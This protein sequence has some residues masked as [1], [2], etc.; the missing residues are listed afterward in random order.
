VECG[1]LRL[2]VT[3]KEDL[4]RSPHFGRIPSDVCTVVL[5]DLREIAVIGRLRERSVPFV[6]VLRYDAQGLLRTGS[7]YHDRDAILHGL[8]RAERT[9]ERPEASFVVDRVLG[10]QAPD[11]LACFVEHRDPR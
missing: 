5:E 2:V 3:E 11:D 9:L 7:T 1:E 10:P 8:R 6:G 4:D